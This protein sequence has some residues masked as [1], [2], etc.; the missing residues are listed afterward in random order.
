MLSVDFELN[1]VGTLTLIVLDDLKLKKLSATTGPAAPAE[2]DKT[3][4]GTSIDVKG[5][6]V[7]RYTGAADATLA[8]IL[9]GVDGKQITIYGTDAVDVDLTVTDVPGLIEVASNAVL[10]TATDNIVLTRVNGVWYETS[11]VI[12]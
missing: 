9:N 2:T 4:T 8:T 7:F 11:R 12:A 1:T 10:G 6:S 5:A 3:F